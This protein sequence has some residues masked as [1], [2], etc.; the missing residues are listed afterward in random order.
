MSKKKSAKKHQEPIEEPA[1]V[2]DKPRKAKPK[3]YVIAKG[4]AICCAG[5]VL[6][7]GSEVTASMF[8][9]DEDVAK[10]A[11]EAHRSMGTIVEK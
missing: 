7:E 2:V 3:G 6:S 1:A 5:R 10:D 11:F 4:R 9:G 8:S